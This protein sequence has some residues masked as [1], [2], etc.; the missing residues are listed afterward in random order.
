[1]APFFLDDGAI[2]T[3]FDIRSDSWV[4]FPF[5]LRSG[6]SHGSDDCVTTDCALRDADAVAELAGVQRLLRR[7]KADVLRTCSPPAPWGQFVLFA[8]PFRRRGYTFALGRFVDCWVSAASSRRPR[9]KKIKCVKRIGEKSDTVWFQESHG[10]IKNFFEH[11]SGSG[12]LGK[13]GTFTPGNVNS[14]GSIG[15][16]CSWTTSTVVTLMCAGPTPKTRLSV[17]VTL[18]ALLAS[19]A[20][21]SHSVENTKGVMVSIYT[22]RRIDCISP[23][24][25]MSELRDIW[26]YFHSI[27]SIGEISVP[28]DHIPVLLATE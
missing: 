16:V 10:R 24:L 28:G 19:L 17:R 14:G 9:D 4:G 26:C 25:P 3:F 12:D 21:F 23:N 15:L 27:G 5:T 7:W 22:L 2:E 18:V 13:I 11:C 1:M 6:S 8:D 20:A